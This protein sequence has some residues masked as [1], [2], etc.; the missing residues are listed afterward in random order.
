MFKKIM[1]KIF[2]KNIN[3]ENK[4]ETNIAWPTSWDYDAVA[5]FNAMLYGMALEKT[6]K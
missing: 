6:T 5:R 1:E 4:Q 3:R 2:R